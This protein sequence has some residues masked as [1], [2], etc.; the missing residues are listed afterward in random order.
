MRERQLSILDVFISNADR[1]LRSM[2]NNTQPTT[3]QSP[4]SDLPENTLSDEER[5]HAASLMRVNHTGEVCAQALYQGQGLTAKLSDVRA[6]ME[7]AADEEIDHLAWC[8]ER[9]NALGSHTSVLNPAWYAM[10]F[11]MGAT[12]GLISDKLSLGFV[13][14]TEDQVCQHLKKHLDELPNEDIRSRAV[15]NHMLEDEARHA[16][17]AKKAGGIPFPFMARTA[18]KALS[19]VMTTVSYRI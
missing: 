9:I 10:S 12:A 5:K 18:M 3:R 6:S 16:E 8:E 17:T 11:S 19:K 7:S 2:T 15:V 14:A 4:A 13:A 1:A